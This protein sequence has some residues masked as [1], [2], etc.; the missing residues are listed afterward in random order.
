DSQGKELSKSYT[1]QTKDEL[2]SLLDD[3]AFVHADKVQL[4]EVIMDKLD[5]PKSLRLMMGAIAKLNTF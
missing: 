5:A 4:V 3:P 2:A 1:V